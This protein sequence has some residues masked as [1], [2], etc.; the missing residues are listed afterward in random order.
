MESISKDQIFHIAKLSRLHLDEHEAEQYA[1]ELGKILDYASRL[2]A[3]HAQGELGQLRLADDEAQPYPDPE[4]LLQ[5]AIEVDNGYVK[6]PSILDKASD[7]TADYRQTNN[8]FARGGTGQTNT[9]SE[10]E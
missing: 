9:E 4:S 3:L 10:K 7:D 2:P 1:M 6:V 5:N 8:Q